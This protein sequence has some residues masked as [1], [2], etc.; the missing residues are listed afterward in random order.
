ME[1]H[2]YFRASS[3]GNSNQLIAL[4]MNNGITVHDGILPFNIAHTKTKRRSE[5]RQ[6]QH[7]EL[8]ISNFTQY[9][10]S[11]HTTLR[12]RHSASYERFRI[13]V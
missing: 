13:H 7:T 5:E 9:V 3:S 10:H 6:Q 11:T 4:L 2:L 1:Y 8:N 12:L